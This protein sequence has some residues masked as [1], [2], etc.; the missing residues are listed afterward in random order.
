M[1]IIVA[2]AGFRVPFY[3][4]VERHGASQ[5]LQRDRQRKPNEIGDVLAGADLRV[6]ELSPDAYAALL[7]E[8]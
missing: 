3:R 8:L 7:E 4:A 2:D 1:P 5:R 6:G